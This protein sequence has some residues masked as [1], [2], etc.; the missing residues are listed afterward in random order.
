MSLQILEIRPPQESLLV[1]AEQKEL[2]LEKSLEEYSKFLFNQLNILIPTTPAG[3]LEF[4]MNLFSKENLKNLKLTKLPAYKSSNRAATYELIVTNPSNR[5]ILNEEK[6]D[7]LS[8][9]EVA[10]V[11]DILDKMIKIKGE[12]SAKLIEVGF[13]GGDNRMLALNFKQQVL[14]GTL[15]VGSQ[16][17]FVE[18]EGE[19]NMYFVENADGNR[20]KFGLEHLKGHIKKNGVQFPHTHLEYMI[21]GRGFGFHVRIKEEEN[22]D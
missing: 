6:N 18:E 22:N 20:F 17:L 16:K 2:E 19:N 14:M 15:F 12:S 9:K 1:K 11:L 10:E 4:F 13:K 7:I 21:G 5:D 8:E 3:K